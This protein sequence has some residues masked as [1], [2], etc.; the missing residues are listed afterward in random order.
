M[1]RLSALEIH[2][3]FINGEATAQS[4][5][6]Y[7]LK[8]I[9]KNDSET[10]AFLSIFKD[11]ALE[12]ARLL[13]LKK[14]QGKPLGK[15]A[16]IPI[17]LKDNIH[18]KGEISTAGSLFLSNYKAVFDATVTSLL[19]EEEALL[20]GKTNMDEFGMGSFTDKSA[21]KISKNPWDLSCSPGGSSGGSSAAVS[22]RYCP[23]SLGSDTG[24]SIRQ[25][26][27]LTGIVGFKPTYG[28]VSRYGLI[29]YASSLDQI[30]PLTSTVSDTAYIMEILGK[31]C[32]K[33]AT[34]LGLAPEPY[35]SFIQKPIRRMKLGVPWHFLDSLDPGAKDNFK[36]AL[37]V[38]ENLGVSTV[39]INLDILKYSLAVYY[40]L[41]TAEASTNL[42]RY[43]GIL[44]GKRSS[45]ATTLDQ[46]YEFSKQEGFGSEVKSR[47]LLGTYVLSSGYK[48]AYYKKAAQVR[49]MIIQEL[50]KAFSSCDLIAMP[51]AP[52]SSFLIGSFQ[53][54]LQ[55]YL[56]DIYTIAANLAG[57]PAISVPSGF[58]SHQKPFGI[59][60]MGPVLQ[61][62]KV[63]QMAH[64]FERA[65]L[66]SKQ[67]PPLFDRE[68]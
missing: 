14:Q 68:A 29:A 7:F 59:Q 2:H 10:G 3:L 9:E 4:I 41:A 31:P 25:P 44:H 28:R 60:L 33:D 64:H 16:G 63:L 51:C 45:K 12:K 55:M 61:D 52:T 47:I 43:D 39:E 30:G 6:E 24:G 66:F 22:A 5:T 53:D 56:Q 49:T 35:F 32:K 17:S 48:E 18:V 42:A 19:E 1:Y 36:Q 26:A 20:I 15:L 50:K 65:T 8:R 23:I 62:A 54:P 11:R 40:I 37:T 58:C 38:F 13:D 67:I 57:L 46:V 27:A 34:N 21:F